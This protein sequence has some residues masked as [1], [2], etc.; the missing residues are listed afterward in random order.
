VTTLSA[1]LPLVIVGAGA[2]GLMAAIHAARG[3]RPTLLLEGGER[4][5]RKILIS[6]GG[7]C[8]VLRAQASAADFVSDGSSH[9]IRKIMAAWPLTRARRFFEE[10][11]RVPLA[12]EAETGK[13]FPASGRARDVLD[14]L[15]T[16]VSERGAHIRANARVTALV[17]EDDGWSVRLASDQVIR[18]HRVILATGGL[19]APAAGSDGSGLR[20]AEQLGHAIIPTYPAL[21]PLIG[22]NPAHRALAGLSLEATVRVE[23]AWGETQVANRRRSSVSSCGGFLFTHRGYSGPAVLNVSH[24]V[25]RALL[26]R[27]LQGQ[28]GVATAPEGETRSSLPSSPQAA[29]GPRLTVQWTA[30]D[31]ATWNARLC[32]EGGSAR[33]LLRQFLPERLAFQ[34]LT[35][36]GLLDADLAQLRRD[37]RGRL[38]EA[39]TRYHLP[40][41]GHE[42]YRAAEVTGGGVSLAEVNP[43]TLESRRAAG[44][45]FCG[46]MLDA[47]GPIGGYNFLW[48]WVTGK[49]AGEAARR[50]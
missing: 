20:I 29:V 38:I 7:R 49:L 27:G 40:V 26:R 33:A 22:G 11:L 6:G 13:L 14:A 34:L 18:A 32:A 1:A 36:T 2:A 48:A 35:E 42:G 5:G 9:T 47:F 10:E 31:A 19:A 46:E 8:N 21:V 39:L 37:A 15:L 16:A 4:P 24:V 17:C 3:P 44:L 28:A 12:L 30:L 41:A 45:F 43:A 25:A 23:E 50:G